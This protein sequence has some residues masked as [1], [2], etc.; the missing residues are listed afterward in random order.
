MGKEG[1]REIDLNTLRCTTLFES[2]THAYVNDCV[3]LPDKILF[4]VKKGD[5]SKA[6]GK[7]GSNINRVRSVFKNKKVY[8][9]EDDDTIEGF[10]KN[11]YPKIDI[12]VTVKETNKGKIA[13]IK[14]DRFKRGAVIGKDG[15]KIKAK[16]ILLKRKFNCDMKVL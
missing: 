15:E 9:V 13:L 14:V 2:L 1:V 16:K 7:G 3:I 8:V 12:Q 5:M 6:I 4:V 11:M 10:I